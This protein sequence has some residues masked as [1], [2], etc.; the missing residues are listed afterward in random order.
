MPGLDMTEVARALSVAAR[1]RPGFAIYEDPKTGK[2]SK[3]KR[4]KKKA[5]PMRVAY[6]LPRSMTLR[7]GMR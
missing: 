5:S 4:V 3:K 1:R 7:F 6:K 2:K